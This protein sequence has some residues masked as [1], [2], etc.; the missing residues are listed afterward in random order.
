MTK[1]DVMGY[2]LE[3]SVAVKVAILSK[4][5]SVADQSRPVALSTQPPGFT[6]G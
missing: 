1:R 6:L 2:K 4:K 3:Q 5:Y